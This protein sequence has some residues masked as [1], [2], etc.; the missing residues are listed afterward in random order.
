VNQEAHQ[1][2]IVLDHENPRRLIRH[3][4]A[5]DT[6]SIALRQQ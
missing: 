1:V 3:R 5:K 6:R 4:R 2:V